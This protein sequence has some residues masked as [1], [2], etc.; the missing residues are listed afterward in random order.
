MSNGSWGGHIG[1]SQ[2]E[3]K[4]GRLDIA[5]SYAEKSEYVLQHFTLGPEY[6]AHQH[7]RGEI[8]SCFAQIWWQQDRRAQALTA[9]QLAVAAGQGAVSRAPQRVCYRQSACEH[10]CRL[11]ELQRAL[12]HS[13]EAAASYE[14]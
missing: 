9:I 6:A 3:Q 4:T 13:A 2:V 5:L 1:L 10:A 14:L 7:L 12:G 11:A 8:L